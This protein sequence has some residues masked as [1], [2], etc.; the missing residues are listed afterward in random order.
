MVVGELPVT[1]PFG[2]AVW[3]EVEPPVP[4]AP[5][6]APDWANATGAAASKAASA[7]AEMNV[8]MNPSVN[9]E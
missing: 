6:C 7:L 3:L 1:E 2:A 9:S 4:S 8:F 5:V